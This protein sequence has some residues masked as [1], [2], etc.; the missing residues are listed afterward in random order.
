MHA[1]LTFTACVCGE[2]DVQFLEISREAVEF[3]H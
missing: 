2:D 1:T 3:H